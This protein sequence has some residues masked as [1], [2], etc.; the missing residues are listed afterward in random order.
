MPRDGHARVTHPHL[1]RDQR[2]AWKRRQHPSPPI[3]PSHDETLCEFQQ[4]RLWVGLGIS[5]CAYECD[6]P[7]AERVPSQ[8]K[9]Q[10]VFVGEDNVKNIDAVKN[11]MTMAPN[12]YVFSGAEAGRKK[13]PPGVDVDVSAHPRSSN[14]QRSRDTPRHKKNTGASRRMRSA[15][16]MGGGHPAALCFRGTCAAADHAS[17]SSADGSSIT[18][19]QSRGSHSFRW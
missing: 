13:V 15:L 5:S 2:S 18:P 8:L 16:P 1:R 10:L 17:R 19:A 14:T 11:L 7:D 12:V 4:W 6:R 3:A 9:Q